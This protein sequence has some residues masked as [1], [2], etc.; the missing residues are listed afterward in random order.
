MLYFCIITDLILNKIKNQNKTISYSPTSRSIICRCIFIISRVCFTWLW[1]QFSRTWYIQELINVIKTKCDL[2]DILAFRFLNPISLVKLGL[3]CGRQMP[4]DC[5]IIL[6]VARNNFCINT[7]EVLSVAL[8]GVCDK[9]VTTV[10]LSHLSFQGV[11][12][13]KE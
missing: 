9:S 2:R 6:K 12:Y 7:R 5:G 13:S 4:V 1:K 11:I 8:V 10:T 3:Y